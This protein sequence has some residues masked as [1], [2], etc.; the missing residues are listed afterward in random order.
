MGIPGR[1]VI[2]ITERAEKM[3]TYATSRALNFDPLL[4]SLLNL[5]T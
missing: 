1:K 3:A 4:L 2:T 5:F